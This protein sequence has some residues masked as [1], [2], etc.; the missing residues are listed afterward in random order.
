LRGHGIRPRA[1]SAIIRKDLREF[2]RDRLWMV[3][4]PVS[5]LLVI[6]VFLILPDHTGSRMVVGVYP[7]RLAEYASGFPEV[8]SG[9]GIEIAG[10]SSPEKLAEAFSSEGGADG[11]SAGVAFP[12]DFPAGLASNEGMTVSLWLSGTLPPGA[13]RALSSG[14]RELGFALEAIVRG[15]DPREQLPVSLPELSAMFPEVGSHGSG[16]STRQLMR[17]M[18][19]ILILLVE[20]LAL[21]GLVSMEIE[22]RT[23]TALLVTPAGTGDLL[24]AKCITGILLAVSQA[25]IFLLATG[26]FAI[27]W[28]LVS[29]LILLGAGMASAVGMMSGAGGR[30]F[31]GT[32]FFGMMFII[33][34]MVPA[35]SV[36][37][38]GRPSLIV[39][40]LPSYGLVESFYG[41]LGQGKGWAFAGPH[42]L[43]TLAWVAALM[44]FALVI[45]RRRVRS[46]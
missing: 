29:V 25:V 12:A 5:L 21:A 37:F 7:E 22:Q 39:R 13:R 10:F 35:I 15:S 32:I 20:A 31:I 16:L 4:T 43:A 8:L 34:L 17:P 27:N 24:T 45:L 28:P 46:L 33:P 6:V 19:V 26:A 9:N 2:S 42:M 36:L 41:V 38:P 1:V 18:L 23:A 11:I 30:D 44:T 3:L 14:I 40:L